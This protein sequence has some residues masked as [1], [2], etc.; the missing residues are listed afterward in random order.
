MSDKKELHA[1]ITGE[2]SSSFKKTMDSAEKRI[3]G[4]TDNVKDFGRNA[5]KAASTMR[6]MARSEEAVSDAS[7]KAAKNIEKMADQTERSDNNARLFDATVVNL[8]KELVKTTQKTEHFG[9]VLEAVVKGLGKDGASGVV[10]NLKT[11]MD[12]AAF[13]VMVLQKV[14]QLCVKAIGDNLRSDADNWKEASDHAQAYAD[15]VANV[16]AILKKTSSQTENSMFRLGKL[17]RQEKLTNTE[18]LEMTQL[19]ERLDG[20]F[21]HIGTTVDSARMHLDQFNKDMAAFLDKNRNGRL[22]G[23]DDQISALRLA[24]KNEDEIVKKYNQKGINALTNGNAGK[25]VQESLTR[26]AAIHDKINKLLLERREIQES[27]TGAGYLRRRQAEQEDEKI[28]LN[29]SWQESQDKALKEL[30]TADAD[31]HLDEYEKKRDAIRKKYE[32]LGK[33]LKYNREALARIADLQAEELAKIDREEADKRAAEAKKKADAEEAAEKKVADARKKYL[34]AEKNL[35]KSIADERVAQ[36]KKAADAEIRQLE[37][38]RRR[39]ERQKGRFGF[40]LDINPDETPSETRKRRKTN[41]IDASIADKQQRQREGE[42]VH[43]SRQERARIGQY[44]DLQ[45]Q[46]KQVDARVKE[47]EAAKKQQEAAEQAKASSERIA[48]AAKKQQEAATELQEAA[49]ALKA[50]RVENAEGEQPERQPQRQQAMPGQKPPVQPQ[51]RQPV[52]PQR[53]MSPI[54]SAVRFTPNYTPQLAAI[55]QSVNSL[56]ANTYIVR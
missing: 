39:I 14:I 44:R 42:R 49:K 8:G 22:A 9:S 5:N 7:N 11:L 51:R 33:T 21:T 43:Y 53:P 36:S 52:S 19:L 6:T 56:K 29:K 32:E 54:A 40:T 23:V 15:S 20:G 34:E 31:L 28:E 55:L 1:I 38:V 41:A 35:R 24:L 10:A 50:F 25:T 37:R 3:K 46:G 27:M 48:E 13:Q 18:Q 30:D 17:L 12:S 26:Q 2:E 47:L 45:K 16:E 4:A